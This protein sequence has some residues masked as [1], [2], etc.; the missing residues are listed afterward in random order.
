MFKDLCLVAIV[1]FLMWDITKR[2]DNSFLIIV[3]NA[4]FALVKYYTWL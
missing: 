2:G 3:M 4:V 1:V